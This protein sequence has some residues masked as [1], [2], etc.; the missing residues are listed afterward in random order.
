[1]LTSFLETPEGQRGVL[2]CTVDSIPQA[3]LALFKDQVLVASTAL[4]Q[5][6]ALPRLSVALAFNTLRVSI[7]P[8]LLEDEGEYVCSASNTYGNASTAANFTAGSERGA[9]VA[10][11]DGQNA[12]KGT[13]VGWSHRNWLRWNWGAMEMVGYGEEAKASATG[14]CSWGRE[15][16]RSWN[17]TDSTETER[18]R[19]KMR[20]YGDGG[21]HQRCSRRAAC[22]P[23]H[24]VKE[25]QLLW[26]GMQRA[27]PAV[28]IHD[29]VPAVLAEPASPWAVLRPLQRWGGLGSREGAAASSSPLV[30]SDRKRVS[31]KN[32]RWDQLSHQAAHRPPAQPPL[33]PPPAHPDHHLLPLPPQLPG[34]GSPPPRTSKKATPST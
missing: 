13:G 27:G 20:V 11:G 7:G 23:P 5:P 3:E 29:A 14:G 25:L 15:A 4:P 16:E 8:V 9:G 24:T 34:S 17:R 32:P 10:S 28:S 19:R 31:D 6:A 22:I 1:M 2:Q 33:H 18:K 30:W 21:L 26:E 12:G